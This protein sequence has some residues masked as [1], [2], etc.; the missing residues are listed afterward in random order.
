[1][2]AIMTPSPPTPDQIAELNASAR[3]QLSEDIVKLINA[4]E[5]D[6]PQVVAA[7][8][9]HVLIQFIM[10]TDTTDEEQPTFSEAGKTARAILRSTIKHT[11]YVVGMNN[12]VI[13]LRTNKEVSPGGLKQ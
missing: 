11:R 10:A 2:E 5:E 7:V 8:L 9:C 13:D 1:M 4:C 6:K 3:T 12:E